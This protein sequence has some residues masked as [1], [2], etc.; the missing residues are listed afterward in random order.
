[1]TAVMIWSITA[2]TIAGVLFRPKEWPEAI[3]AC[4]GATLMVLLRL[5]SPAEAGAAIGKG[6]DVYLFLSGMMLLADLARRQGVFDWL[7]SIAVSASGGSSETLFA[8][9]YTV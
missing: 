6:Y 4:L 7:A 2:G 5:I 1:M 3:W 9:V 8:I